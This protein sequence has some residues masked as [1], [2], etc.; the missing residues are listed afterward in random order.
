M[1]ASGCGL[2][3]KM[4]RNYGRLINSEQLEWLIEKISVEV[5]S[6]QEENESVSS[7]VRKV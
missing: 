2:F 1:H 6:R 5:K 3:P 4:T 7:P